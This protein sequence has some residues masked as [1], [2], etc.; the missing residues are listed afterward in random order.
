MCSFDMVWAFFHIMHNWQHL[1]H[2]IC[3][4]FFAGEFAKIIAIMITEFMSLTFS[5]LKKYKILKHIAVIFVKFSIWKKIVYELFFSKFFCH[6]MQFSFLSSM[7]SSKLL[8]FFLVIIHF[9]LIWLIELTLYINFGSKLFV[10][11]WKFT[12]F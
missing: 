5:K 6:L 8:D 11:W 2:K 12:S 1:L 3:I 10:T 7:P 4:V 9:I